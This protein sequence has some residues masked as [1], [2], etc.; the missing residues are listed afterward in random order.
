MTIITILSLIIAGCSA[1]QIKASV[2]DGKFRFVN[3]EK[4]K[5]KQF[6]YIHLMC[7]YQRP[8]EWNLPKQYQAGKHLLW[9]KAQIYQKGIRSSEKNAFVKFD[10]TLN[11][12]ISYKLNRSFKENKISIW[13]E[14]EKTKNIVSEVITSDL[15]KPL[16]VEKSIRTSQC[17][18]GTI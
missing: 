11:E 5:G 7:L 6:E 16:L 13:I 10:I 2:E 1:Y 14:E 4:E 18:N 15:L 3:F 12:G 9:V 17:E 8:I